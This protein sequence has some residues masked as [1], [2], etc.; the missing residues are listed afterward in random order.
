MKSLKITLGLKQK[1]K[2]ENA[3]NDTNEVYLQIWNLILES[4]MILKKKRERD[5]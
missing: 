1:D 3:R 4:T 5:V 2:E